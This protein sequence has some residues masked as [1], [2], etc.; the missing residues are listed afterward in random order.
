[1]QSEFGDGEGDRQGHEQG[2]ERVEEHEGEAHEGCVGDEDMGH[3]GE[4]G[5]RGGSCGWV[6]CGLGG[7]GVSEGVV[8][9]EGVCG[10]ATTAA[11]TIWGCGVVGLRGHTGPSE[12]DLDTAHVVVDGD[13]G[14]HGGGVDGYA[15]AVGPDEGEVGVL[16]VHGTGAV[17]PGETVVA[18][19]VGCH[20]CS[21]VVGG[22]AAVGEGGGGGVDGGDAGAWE[23]GDLGVACVLGFEV[24]EAGA[25]GECDFG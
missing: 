24:A 1:M 3:F 25:R 10:V 7:D 14:V 11:A 20:G 9:G 8:V 17:L 6:G 19:E 4:V 5:E 16:G 23:H 13:V 22:G 18:A 12:I 15:G 21:G 2:R